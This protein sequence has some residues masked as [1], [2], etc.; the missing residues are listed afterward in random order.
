MSRFLW[1]IS[2]KQ[3]KSVHL[4]CRVRLVAVSLS[5]SRGWLS[6]VGVNLGLGSNYAER[7]VIIIIILI[8]VICI[9]IVEYE[10]CRSGTIAECQQLPVAWW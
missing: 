7:I 8:I 6:D 5:L 3:K 10:S 4:G 9:G 2:Q 1:N